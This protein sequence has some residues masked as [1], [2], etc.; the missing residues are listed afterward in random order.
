MIGAIFNVGVHVRFQGKHRVSYMVT[1]V[2]IRYV[3]KK[4]SAYEPTMRSTKFTHLLEV[5]CSFVQVIN[6]L[7]NFYDTHCFCV[8]AM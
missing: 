1:V 2:N 7:M 5:V 6:R 8:F 4:D 3:Q